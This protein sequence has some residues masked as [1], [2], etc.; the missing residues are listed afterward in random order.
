MK[1]IDCYTT[2]QDEVVDLEL[3]S[4]SDMPE[5][6]SMWP[7]HLVNLKNLLQFEG[8]SGQIFCDVNQNG[9]LN[10]V[11]LGYENGDELEAVAKAVMQLPAKTFQFSHPVSKPVYT[12]WG[13]AQY[14]FSTFKQ[15]SYTPR[16][17]FL[18]Q[19]VFDEVL[20]DVG[21]VYYARDL[22]NMPPNEMGPSHLAKMLSNLAD[23][24]H[25]QFD[26]CLDDD[27]LKQNYP[28]IHA[29]GRAA[30]NPPRLLT[31]TWGDESKPTVALVGK[32]VCFDTG[33]LNLKPG[34]SM[35]LM[36]K[37]MGGAAQVMGLAKWIMTNKLPIHLKVYIPAVENAISG[38][39]FRPGDIITMRNQKTVE[40]DNTDAEGRLV[41]ADALV[42]A[43]EDG[44]QIIFDFATL[45]GAARV[46]VGTDISALFSND[47]ALADKLQSIGELIN[48]PI[49]PMPLH[50]KYR[51]MLDSSCADLVNSSPTP[52]AGAITAALFLKEFVPNDTPWCHF[53]IMAWNPSSKPGKPEGGEAMA[54]LSVA[55]YLKQSYQ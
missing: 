34:N 7:E 15:T 25:G 2:S 18:E 36:K 33:G 48:D 45:T 53:D 16:K 51:K 54:L 20:C 8:R 12:A 46:A 19:P 50:A 5:L 28:A 43:S 41:L 27:L 49:W 11:Y 6:E 47:K 23:E 9:L 4:P 17:L 35:R 37:D 55:H 29:V 14:Q 30:E 42:K 31:L 40:I 13:L 10:K 26:Q 32:G 39:A 22:I 38:N 24:H 1:A 21:A 52:Y 44:A 3:V